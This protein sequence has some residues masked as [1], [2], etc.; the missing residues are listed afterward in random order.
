MKKFEETM[1]IRFLH[2]AVLL[3]LCFLPAFAQDGD[4]L[5]SSDVIRVETDLVTFEVVVTDKSGNPITGLR[6]EDFQIL[7]DG[8][9]RSFDFFEPMQSKD[10]A[11]PLFMVLAIDVSGSITNEELEKLR[12][13]LGQFIEKLAN[14][15]SYFAVMT[16][17]MKV[18]TILP[19]TNKPEKI[20]KSLLRFEHE[21]DGLSTH[22]YDAAYEAVRLLQRKTPKVIDGKPTRQVVVLITDGFPVGDVVSPKT[23]IES[24]NDAGVTV[25]SI[26][27]PSYSGFNFQIRRPILTPLEASG[28]MEKTGGK[29]FYP[30]KEGLKAILDLL[31]SEIKGTYLFAFYPSEESKKDGKFRTVQIK[32]KRNYLVRQNRM[33]Y[34]FLQ[35]KK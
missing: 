22:A 14:Y 5:V 26:I 23:V 16:F 6:A 35:R 32:T 25:Y 2:A 7:E 20:R 11:R 4:N 33:G 8:V 1:R 3:V 28:L 21:K 19:F 29:S 15:E 30:T 12:F 10:K 31:A 34:Q 17:G 13:I 18:K 24:A 9:E 27:L